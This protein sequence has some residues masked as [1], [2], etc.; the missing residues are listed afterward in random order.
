MTLF[1]FMVL[2]S[3]F[4]VLG[5]CCRERVLSGKSETVLKT[6]HDFTLFCYGVAP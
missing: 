6:G 1:P 4:F 2:V 5:F 3:C